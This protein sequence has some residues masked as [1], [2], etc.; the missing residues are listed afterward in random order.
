MKRTI[1]QSIGVLT[2]LI[3]GFT[4]QA[5][6]SLTIEGSQNITNFKFTNSLGEK[7]EGYGSSYSGGYALGYK[8]SLENGMYFPC[9]IGMRKAGATYIYDNANYLWSFNYFETRLGIGY[10]YSFGKFG[11]HISA[12]GYFGYLL[13]ANQRLNNQ[14]FDIRSTGDINKTDVGLFISPGANFTANEYISV[15]IDLNY[16]FGLGNLETDDTQK[17][18]NRMFGA[19]LGLAFTIK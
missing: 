16:M 11:A 17:S 15:Y 18:N 14:D 2:C 10:N 5:Q 12:M 6:S 7:V 3:M 1:I 13:K 19:T 8:Y 9:K 4:S